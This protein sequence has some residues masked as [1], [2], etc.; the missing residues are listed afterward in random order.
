MTGYP[1]AAGPVVTRVLDTGGDGPVVL[2]LH[3]LGARA[4]RWAPT[5]EHVAHLGLRGVAY[6]HPGHGFATK[7]PGPDYTIP[8]FADVLDAVVR[9]LGIADVHL[10]GTSLGGAV[11]ARWAARSPAGLRSLVLVGAMGLVPLATPRRLAIRDSVVDTSREGIRAKLQGVFASTG[12]VDPSLVEVEHRFNTSPGAP[13]SFAAL[14]DYVVDH[15]DDDVLDPLSVLAPLRP[16]LVWGADDGVI[17]PAVGAEAHRLVPGSQLVLIDGAGHAP[18][19]EQPAAFR[20]AVEPIWR[21]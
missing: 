10:V 7:G 1:L 5:L 15:S 19:L 12:I 4:D 21:R 2:F 14:G 17:P 13:E 9:E 18:Y 8:G 3:G 11:A 20:E 6:D 16:L